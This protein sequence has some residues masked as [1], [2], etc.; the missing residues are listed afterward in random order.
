MNDAFEAI[1]GYNLDD[2]KGRKPKD[3]LQRDD[4][5]DEPRQI[6][7]QALSKKED[8][9]VTIVNYNKEGKPY[10]N[11]LEI[12]SV[13][14]E[15]GEHTHFIAL[16]KDITN[17]ILFK[18]ELVKVNSR[19]ELIANQSKIGI[20]E[21]DPKT[22]TVVWSDVLLQLYGISPNTNSS[23]LQEKWKTAILEEDRARVLHSLEDL[24][25]GKIDSIE[26]EF[27]M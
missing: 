10:Y 22:N 19:F 16:Q 26:L 20:W 15:K 21:F 13:F 24:N 27:R 1:S 25:S 3:F 17:E 23:Q 6:L 12:I 2:V 14:N 5:E 9:E 8:V 4:S 7:K 11:N 18:Q